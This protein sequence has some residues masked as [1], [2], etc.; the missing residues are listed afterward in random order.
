MTPPAWL[1]VI[2]AIYIPFS[3][4]ERHLL[5]KLEAQFRDIENSIN[6]EIAICANV[7]MEIDS[8]SERAKEIRNNI[9]TLKYIKG[10][11]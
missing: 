9:S 3:L 5:A 7:I 4:Y 11:L 8:E 10:K 1:L 2:F 6:Q